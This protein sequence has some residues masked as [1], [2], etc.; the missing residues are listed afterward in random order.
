[1]KQLWMYRGFFSFHT[2]LYHHMEVIQKS[3]LKISLPNKSLSDSIVTLLRDTIESPQHWTRTS[4]SCL[5]SFFFYLFRY[6]VYFP[7]YLP[8]AYSIVT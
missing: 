6:I 8:C 5:A 3:C 7:S 2:R 1:M 4:L